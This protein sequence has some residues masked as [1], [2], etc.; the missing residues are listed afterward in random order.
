MTS[1]NLNFP[2][3]LKIVLE[4]LK[5]LENKNCIEDI[6][7]VLEAIANEERWTLESESLF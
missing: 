1:S 5:K 4:V 2:H 6:N 7:L 3:N